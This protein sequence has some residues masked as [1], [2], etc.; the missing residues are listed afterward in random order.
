MQWTGL[1]TRFPAG[2]DARQHHRLLVIHFHP[3]GTVPHS[4]NIAKVGRIGTSVSGNSSLSRFEI[5]FR[6]GGTGQETLIAGW[7]HPEAEYTWT[8]GPKSVLQLPA[9]AADCDHTLKLRAGPMVQQGIARFQRLHVAV[10]GTTI[11]RLV[12]R[13]TA[14]FELHVPAE[15]LKRD[16]PT[17]IVFQMPDARAPGEPGGAGDTR[18]LGVWLSSLQF[19]PLEGPAHAAP[20]GQAAADKAMLMDLQS[21]GENCELGLVQR[22]GG[23]EPWGLFRWAATP[24]PNLLAALNARFDGLGAAENLAIEL[25]GASEFQVLDR[26]FGFK[27]HSF[28]FQS[29][30]ARAEDVL[31]REMVRLP[32]MAR[33]LIKDL[34]AAQKLFCFHDAGRSGRER[35]E[36]LVEALGRYG[37]NWLL[38]VRPAQRAEQVGTAE[39]VGDRLIEGYIDRFEPLNNVRTPSVGAWMGVVRAG[40]GI[41]RRG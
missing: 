10:N 21:L 20:G 8:L 1:P 35:I 7:S 39:R 19:A 22:I 41:W 9:G 6:A 37:P 33:L 11:A 17:E 14:H 16:A 3:F 4:C 34:E 24:L 26:R 13:G 40:C 29:A 30:G 18:E 15:A 5:D 25:D 27:N 2:H 28:A 31:K 38:W 36:V 23:V 32:Y 12:L